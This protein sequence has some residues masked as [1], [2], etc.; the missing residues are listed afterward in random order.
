MLFYY[1]PRDAIWTNCRVTF[2]VICRPIAYALCNAV[3][4]YI[5]LRL[6]IT[7]LSCWFLGVR[8]QQRV[9]SLAEITAPKRQTTRKWPAAAAAFRRR[10]MTDFSRSTAEMFPSRTVFPLK[11]APPDNDITTYEFKL[12]CRPIACSARSEWDAAYCYRCRT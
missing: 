7:N 10:P 2:V 12:S 4:D 11:T 1:T 8:C 6:L 9:T 3:E 5:A